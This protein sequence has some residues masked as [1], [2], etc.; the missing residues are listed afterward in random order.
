[1]FRHRL[2]RRHRRH[3]RS[4]RNGPTSA[5]FVTSRKLNFRSE[6]SSFQLNEGQSIGQSLLRAVLLFFGVA[7]CC[8]HIC[9][10]VYYGQSIFGDAEMANMW[11]IRC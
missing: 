6:K 2:L 1:M 11:E 8:R 9:Q 5:G 10:H 4:P 3:R 7:H